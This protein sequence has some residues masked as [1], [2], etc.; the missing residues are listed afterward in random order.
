MQSRIDRL[1]GLVLSLMT[2]G[3]QPGSA[4]AARAAISNSRSDGLSTA[5]NRQ[6]D[7]GGEDMNPEGAEGED[8]SEVEGISRGI[9][10]MKVDNGKTM[11][12]SDQ[13]WY[14]ILGELSEVKRYFENH[15]E[16]YK[17]HMAKVEAAKADHSSGTAFLFQASPATDKSELLAT[18]PSKAD[19]DR[20]IARYF[21]A[22]DPSAHIIHGP[23]FQ[24][25][26]DKHWLNPNETAVP[27]LGMCFAMMT[28]A[29]QSYHRAG[30]EPAEYRGRALQLS[31]TYGRLTAQC[32]VLGDIT[33]G[34]P[35]TLETLLLYVQLE[36][37]RSKDVE[38]S[39]L[40][41]TS[42]CVRLAERMGYHRDPSPHSAITP[43]QGEMRR[44]VWTFVRQCD[45][46]VSFQHGM[47]ALIRSD[48]SDTELPRN[49]YDD[50]LEETKSLPPSRPRFEATPMSY[51]IAKAR[52][53]FLFG[54]IVERT[55]SVSNPP[56]Y[57]E[58]L[59]F[60][61]ELR[62]M[63]S[64][65]PPLFQM[66]SFQ[67]S[68]RDSANIIMQRLCLEMVY[69]RTLF[70][71]HRRF[72]AKG[73]E[74]PRYSFSRRTCLDASME[75]LDH[76]ATLHRE[77]QSGGRLKS[78][79]WYIS[80]LTAHDFVL[81]AMLL[82]LDLYRT[83]EAEK[84]GRSRPQSRAEP[85]SDLSDETRR[86]QMMQAM[87]H[88]ITVWE[89]V[90]DQSM[91]AYKASI[92][93]RLMVEKLK[94]HQAQRDASQHELRGGG[95]RFGGFPNGTVAGYHGD[96]LPPEQSAAMTLEMLSSGAAPGPSFGMHM[97]PA[98][99]APQQAYPTGMTGLMHDGMHERAG[100]AAPYAVPDTRVEN[101]LA[102]AVSPLSQIL[103]QANQF[104]GSDA[105]GGDL[106][107]K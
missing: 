2:S 39:I 103:A 26:Y 61:R 29:L 8:E 16:D 17:Q 7:P 92:A 34:N 100:L 52:M 62:D 89:S 35:Q 82:C 95:M 91:E 4:G 80:S 50:E 31:H 32:L 1:E 14:A 57:E 86:E 51:M 55:Q 73:R 11:F 3:S 42:I 20:L 46:L 79:K 83:A 18:F 107:C 19:A 15:K 69:L 81:A 43:F 71:L 53:T 22:Y 44:R 67:D 63:R 5:S 70:V 104:M 97:A 96:D 102:G 47:S 28:L 9:G 76:Q 40:L 54:Q 87:E 56:L 33:Q 41:L 78:V 64:Q 59:A 94:A 88:C 21:G 90:R 68:A 23:S 99:S 66:R 24:K 49:I 36:L 48:D 65:H 25:Q 27:W 6:V 30:D 75:L 77:S 72:V 74:N 37:G 12:A 58:T 13:H 105:T 45:L 101:G 60:D 106:D 93:L 84:S 38:P 98:T 85:S 10:F